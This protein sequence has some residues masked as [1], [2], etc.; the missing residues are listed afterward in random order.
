MGYVVKTLLC[1]YREKWVFVGLLRLK[2]QIMQIKVT[3]QSLPVASL[4]LILFQVILLIL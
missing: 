1:F 3:L 4:T 2:N